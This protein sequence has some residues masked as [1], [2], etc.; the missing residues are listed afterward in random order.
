MTD[1]AAAPAPRRAGRARELVRVEGPAA[2][3]IVVTAAVA[4]QVTLWLGADRPPVFAA[5][6][7]LVALRGD[8]VTALGTSLQRTLGVVA[9]VLIGI[10]VLNVCCG[11]PRARRARPAGP[12]NPQRLTYG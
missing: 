6:V 7:P 11:P 1:L 3:R 12:T 8:P 4:W 10:A 2:A 5:F 9:G